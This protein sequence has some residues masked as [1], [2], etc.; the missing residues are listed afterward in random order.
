MVSTAAPS[1]S[2]HRHADLRYVTL[3]QSRCHKPTP[4]PGLSRILSPD[5]CRTTSRHLAPHVI[6]ADTPCSVDT[7]HTPLTPSADYRAHLLDNPIHHMSLVILTLSTHVYELWY[8]TLE[9][10]DRCQCV[11]IVICT[12]IMMYYCGPIYADYGTSGF[13]HPFGI[14]WLS[15]SHPLSRIW[16]FSWI[17]VACDTSMW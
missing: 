16:R 15:Y 4:L 11:V 10:H 6:A 1:S 9:L 3:T 2:T 12:P 14:L 5:F 17:I 8:H 13:S 7:H